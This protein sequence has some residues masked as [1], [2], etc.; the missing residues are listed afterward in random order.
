MR[1]C[2]VLLSPTYGMHMVAADLAERMAAAGHDVHVLTTAR[3]PLGCYSPA[4]TLHTPASTRNSGFSLDALRPA[5]FRAV[6]RALRALQPEIVHITGPHLWNAPLLRALRAW[7]V[8]TVHSL[9]DPAPHSGAPYGRLLHLWN[10]SI[11]AL[12][13]HILVHGDCHRQALLRAGVPAER[14]TSLPLLHLFTPPALHA[15][16]RPETSALEYQPWALFFGRFEAYKGLADLLQ[17]AASLPGSG[18][19]P[20]VVVAGR[21]RLDAD[22]RTALPAQVELRNRFIPDDEALDLFRR[23]GLLVLPYRDATQSALIAAAYYW[24]K[25]V[26]V[27]RVG[28]LPEYVRDGVTGWVVEPRA[29]EQLARVLSEALSDPTRLAAMGAAGRAWYAEQRALEWAGLQ[30]MY[31]RV[32]ATAP[33]S[34]RAS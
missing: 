25:P 19:A 34:Q 16:E 2:Y 11:V 31:A 24:H 6:R 13:D 9:H 26:L 4:I 32:A 15:E 28:A 18:A 12:A 14:V 7:G 10:R 33:A 3:A 23:C 27:T 22:W 20:R 8:P 30:S 17:A 29:P 21:G 1:I 5:G